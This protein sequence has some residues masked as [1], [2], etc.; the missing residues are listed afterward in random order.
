MWP[1]SFPMRHYLF[2]SVPHLIE[3][4]GARAHDTAELRRGWHGWRERLRLG[5]VRLPAQSMLRACADEEALDP[6]RPRVTHLV[7]EWVAGRGLAR[8]LR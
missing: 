6:S 7:Q 1:V 8:P 4:Y 3:K 5:R 2:L